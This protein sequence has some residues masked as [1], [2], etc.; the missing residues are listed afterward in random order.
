MRL[1]TLLLAFSLL[2]TAACKKGGGGAKGPAELSE[3]QALKPGPNFDNGLAT[4]KSPDKA[5]NVDYGAAY[6]Y[7]D[8]AATLGGGAKA[9]FNAGWTAER[10][11]RPQDAA[12]HF[13]AALDADPTMEPAMFSLASAYIEGGQADQAVELYQAYLAKE[14]G[15]QEVRNELVAALVKANRHDEAIG[16]AQEILRHDPKNAQVFRSLSAMYFDKDMIGMA[17]LTAEQSLKNSPGDPG[18]INNMGVSLLTQGK[19]PEAIAKFKEAINLDVK[20]FEANYNMGWIALNSGDYGLANTSFDN[21]LKS[22]PGST[23]AKMGFAVAKRGIGEL[24]E[25]EKLYSE[26]MA[27]EPD[28]EAAFFNAAVL[29][30][31]YVKDF[32]KAL[33]ILQTYADAH[34]VGADHEVFARMKRV[35]AAKAEEDERKRIEAERKKAEEERR[36]RNQ[37]LLKNMASTITKMQ[38]QLSMNQA[39]IDPMVTEEVNMVLEQAQ[40]VVDAEEVDMAADIQSMLEGYQPVIDDAVGACGGSGGGEEGTD[41]GDG[42]EGGEG[43]GGE[44]TEGE[45]T[46]GMDEEMPEE[47]GE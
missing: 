21:A 27:A 36:K 17:N 8:K 12:M 37:E 26:I 1:S 14:P 33:K 32:K 22:K 46:E 20:H 23:K 6:N 16:A 10:L 2:T 41:G 7:F 42:T 31:V 19:E 44:G 28:N 34:P 25:A 35:E 24:K 43:A 13:K 38:E 29:Q 15:N 39:C 18:T 3:D 5:G 47:G 4:L 30:E 9:H 45:E 11:G 40:M